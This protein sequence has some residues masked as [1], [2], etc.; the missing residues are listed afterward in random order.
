[1]NEFHQVPVSIVPTLI[2]GAVGVSATVGSTIVSMLP[3]IE[4]W[5]RIGSLCV[6]ICV[7]LLTIRSI[8]KGSNQK[9]QPPENQ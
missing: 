7:G 2:R 5:L 6:G 8:L 3:Q 4:A 9:S 1:M